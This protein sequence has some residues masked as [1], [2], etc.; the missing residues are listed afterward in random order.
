[1]DK[2]ALKPIVTVVN[3]WLTFQELCHRTPLFSEAYLGQPIGEFLLSNYRTGRFEPELNHP[4]LNSPRRGRPN[5]LDYALFSPGQNAL[6]TAIECKWITS[7]VYPKQLILDDLLRLECVRFTGRHVT[8]YFLVAGSTNHFD[9]NFRDA[10]INV[11]GGRAPFAPE[12]LPFKYGANSK[13]SVSVLNAPAGLRKYFKEFED[14]YSTE[15]PKTFK[16]ELVARSRSSA[17]ATYLWQISSVPNRS[18]FSPRKEWS[19]AA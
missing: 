10:E 7:R 15:L 2:S 14:G 9:R 6:V 19:G 13:K 11:G 8:R 4:T 1:M 12:L 16:T 3:R 17:I 18:L 5:Q